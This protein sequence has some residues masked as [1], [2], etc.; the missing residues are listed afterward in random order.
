MKVKL[1]RSCQW[2]SIG[3]GTCEEALKKSNSTGYACKSLNSECY[4]A[5]NGYGYRCSCMQGYEG[6]PYLLH[7][8]RGQL[9]IPFNFLFIC[10]LFGEKKNIDECRNPSTYCVKKCNG[11][12]DG[13]DCIPN[14]SGYPL[15]SRIV[16]V[17][18][19][20]TTPS[21]GATEML[22]ISELGNNEE[23]VMEV[24]ELA[25][26]CLNVRGDERPSMKEVAAELEGLGRVG[27][28][29]SWVEPKG[30]ENA[31]SFLLGDGLFD[32]SVKDHMVMGGG[33]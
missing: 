4:E 1:P 8:C 14:D 24:A 18:G 6:N 9:K 15:I 20:S 33:R 19:Y 26:S 22:D 5:S 21:S 13:K 25:R 2:W 11:R 30:E 16:T 32:D 12:K 28:K 27:G 10:V 7:G 23:Q 17:F 3:N 31:E 29:H